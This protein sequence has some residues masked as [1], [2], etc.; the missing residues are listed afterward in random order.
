M[1]KDIK[2][3]KKPPMPSKIEGRKFKPEPKP[4]PKPLPKLP[5]PDDT[6]MKDVKLPKSPPVNVDV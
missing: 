5:D 2:D 6:E 4:K 3:E 1:K